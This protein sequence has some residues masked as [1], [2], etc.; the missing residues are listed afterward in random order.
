ME[1]RKAEMGLAHRDPGC[2]TCFRSKDLIITSYHYNKRVATMVLLH[3]TFT[4]S[5][6]T[7]ALDPH[8]CRTK[9]NSAILRMLLE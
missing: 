1:M 5:R 3:F 8:E 4:K 6:P 2:L 7:S 9:Q